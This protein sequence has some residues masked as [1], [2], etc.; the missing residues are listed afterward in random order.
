MECGEIS[1]A[2]RSAYYL[3]EERK[4]SESPRGAAKQGTHTHGT[5]KAGKMG[6]IFRIVY[7]ENRVRHRDLSKP[8]RLERSSS[9]KAEV[10]AWQFA[11]LV[12]AAAKRRS[13]ARG[14]THRTRRGFDAG[15]R[16]KLHECANGLRGQR[17]QRSPYFSVS[18]LLCVSPTLF[19][20]VHIP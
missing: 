15:G 2:F 13:G 7:L 16:P 5:L 3:Q 11:A 19:S 4:V 14:R 20:G 9:K 8:F 10:A 1:M 18:C 6:A 12:G 17:F